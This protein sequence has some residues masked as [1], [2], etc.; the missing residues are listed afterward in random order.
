MLH[1]RIAIIGSISIDTI[2]MLGKPPFQKLGGVVIYGGLTLIRHGIGVNIFCNVSPNDQWI[3]DFFKTHHFEWRGKMQGA[4]TQF[5]NK[6]NRNH[7]RQEVSAIAEPIHEILESQLKNVDLVYLGPLHPEDIHRD[8]VEFSGKTHYRIVLD[9]QGYTRKI[10]KGT[11]LPQVSPDVEHV[12]K[13]VHILKADVTELQLTLNTFGMDIPEFQAHFGIEELIVTQGE[14]G[15]YG[16]DLSGRHIQYF[17]PQIIEKGD[18]TGAGDVFF[19]AYLCARFLQ[20]Q[21]MEQALAYGA[22]IS[23]KHIEGNFIPQTELMCKKEE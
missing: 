15:G 5:V 13:W 12:L 17:P 10:E 3:L 8:V 23:A 2:E 19:S 22:K 6:I 14:K 21:S 16:H 1:N 4:T 7:R 11:V 20:N 9:I 18:S